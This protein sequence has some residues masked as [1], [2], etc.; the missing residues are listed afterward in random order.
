[1]HDHASMN[2]VY[3]LVW[4]RTRGA[5]VA[6]A[7]TARGMGKAVSGRRLLLAAL[8][9]QGAAALAA[10]SGG[11]ISAGGGSISS[12]G[13]TTTINQQSQL[14]AIN[15]QSFNIG[16]GETVNF[17]QPN[18]LSVAL[19]RVVG[20]NPTTILGHLNAN[21]QV[22]LI[23]TNGVLFGKGAEVDVNGLIATTLDI[24]DSDFMAGN[25]RF[26]NSGSAASVTNQ[27][28]LTA[29]SGGYI[30]LLGPQVSNQGTISATL[31]TVL[32]GAGDQI[33]VT[34]DNGTLAGFSTD[35]GTLNALASNGQL[36]EANG[37]RVI[38]SAKAVDAL[39][40]AVV[41][42]SGVVEAQT[43]QNQG[44]SIS[45]VADSQVTLA[46]G[47][48]LDASAPV[49]G[50]GGSIDTSAAHVTVQ[51]GASV[52]TSA[53]HG[54]AGQW[55]IDPVDFTIAATGGDISGSEL[56][57]ELGSGNVTI[58]SNSGATGGAGDI[59]VN[60]SVS[61][62]ANQL[63]LSA[64]HDINI[65]A[66]LNGSAG[67]S[68]GL[69][70]GLGAVNAGNTASYTIAAGASINLPAGK[71]L[72][73]QLGSDGAVVSYQ[74]ID[75]L[76]D[77]GSTSGTDL[78]GMGANLAGNYALGADID[79]SATAGW[80]SGS[81]FAPIGVDGSPF[82]GNFDGLGHTIS[83]LS[84]TQSSAGDI[85]LFGDITGSISNVGLID[86]SVSGKTKVGTLAGLLDFNGKI[87]NSY[88]TDSSVTG[89]GG[90]SVGGLVGAAWPGGSINNS[91]VSGGTVAGTDGTGGLAGTSHS[92]ITNSHVS[93]T[94][95]SGNF[96]VGGMVGIDFSTI[97]NSYVS[98]GSVTGLS[99]SVGGLAGAM[100]G[101]SVS[102]S[103]VS[104][105]TISG[106]YSVGGLVGGNYAGSSISNSYVSGGSISGDHYV[107]GLVGGSY[108]TISNSY[109]TG[110]TVSGRTGIGGLLGWNNTAGSVSGSYASAGSV[111]GTGS[112]GGLVGSNDGSV[113]GS[114]WNS[115][116]VTTGIGAGNLTG[117]T[118]LSSTAMMQQSSFTGFDFGEGWFMINGSTLPF[119]QSEYSTTISNDHQLQLMAMN[120][121]ANY[122][123]VSN[124]DFGT[125]LTAA[126]GM[127]NSATG[128]VPLGS[129]ATPFTGSLDGT[130]HSI[131][132]LSISLPTTDAVGLFADTS[133]NI[134][135]IGLVNANVSGNTEVGGLAGLTSGSLSNTYVSGGVVSGYLYVG[136]LAGKTSATINDSQASSDTTQGSNY[137]GSLAGE[138]LGNVSDSDGT[139]VT[140]LGKV[141]IGGL[142]G[143]STGNFT[144]THVTDSTI[145]GTNSAGGLVGFTYGTVS[146][147]Y[148]SGGSVVATLRSAGGLVGANFGGTITNSY[149][150]GG[151]VSGGKSVG[152]LVGS[153]FYGK[154]T[155]SYV[156]GGTVSGSTSVGGLVGGNGAT[157]IISGSYVSGGSISG[158]QSTGGLVGSNAGTIS[159][160]TVSD[161]SVSGSSQ[162]GQV[163]GWNASTGS[164]TTSSASNVTIT[165]TGTDVG[166]LIGQNDAG[167]SGTGSSGTGS[168]GTGSPGTGS[169]GTGS[170][171]TGS[172]GTGSSGTGS[173]G[174]GSSGTGSSGTGSS[175]TGSSGTGSSGTG[176]SGTG[177]SGT[178][179]S[180][181]GSSGTGSSGTGSSGTGSSGTGS[182]GTGSSGTGSSGTGSSGTGSSGTGSSGTGS[183]GSG[184]SPVNGDGDG[185]GFLHS[186]PIT[187]LM[188]E[189]AGV[190]GNIISIIEP[191][192]AFRPHVDVTDEPTRKT[193]LPDIENGG[194]RLP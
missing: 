43:I 182:S 20:Q 31:G 187:S 14:L 79:A 133:G 73:T 151:S 17:V 90:F 59:N 181:T 128:F 99:L 132:G 102:N 65:N 115:S 192:S 44:G 48:S 183:S 94:T 88:A 162:V 165:G 105:G 9:L 34:I 2:R 84:I 114:Y 76:G 51:N 81:G 66:D 121:S 89:S 42:N 123:L 104:G 159:N 93:D 3:R 177:S 161:S 5:W 193:A 111:T 140:V 19:N 117:A 188:A 130:G 97:S 134:S 30:A 113:S 169:S 126:G 191:T 145:S 33:S 146:N 1:M 125:D 144:D 118:G 71:T 67:A 189:A 96:S 142:V 52:T 173:S 166:G 179:S 147:S 86:A 45:L 160:S 106:A 172:S 6:V 154:V 62:S 95:V 8:A 143:A 87:N 27:G 29:A 156:S 153:N 57:Q 112:I 49:S 23:N 149:V 92:T 41:N 101:G 70:Y 36:I 12:S 129:S 53:A 75:S 171:G 157:G 170:S 78:Q 108:G 85:G 178:G 46:S 83:H 109:D 40:S 167:S 28:S 184:S 13:T 63:T 186:L 58:E 185:G 98:G 91:Y 21:G 174:T 131:T 158:G 77:A 175:G 190:F 39:A 68:L 168:S 25:N 138:S 7:E 16:A 47:S 24:S 139:T 82:T 152:G 18:S 74:V 180:G 107:G 10:P 122:T 135:N 164:V 127:W 110:S 155:D 54:Q 103:Y 150:S 80:N 15:W 69:Q 124:I 119:L 137:V 22:F 32:L 56:A 26:S 4:S 61:W 35:R 120:T 60:D 148:V 100:Y 55:V 38:L 176:S 141:G 37:G 64:Q 136:G 163:V 11:A 72:T 116:L 194:V 50:N